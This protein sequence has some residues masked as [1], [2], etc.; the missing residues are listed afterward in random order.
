[1]IVLD[2]D[3]VDQAAWKIAAQVVGRRV[4]LRDARL[5]VRHDGQVLAGDLAVAESGIGPLDTVN[6]SWAWEDIDER[7]R[8]T[9]AADVR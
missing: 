5:V 4:P 9:G 1:M 6:V 8:R 2:T 3:T 7:A